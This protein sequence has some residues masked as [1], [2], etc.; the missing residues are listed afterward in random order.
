MTDTLKPSPWDRTALLA[1]IL[2]GAVAAIWTIVHAVLRII[3]IAPNRDVPVTASFADTA[4]TLPLGPDGAPVSVIAQQVVI[5]VSDMPAITLVSLILAE[6]VY[7]LTVVITIVCVCLVTRNL[8]AGRAFARSTVGLVGTATLTVAFGWVLTWLFTTM[9]A[10]G[11][12]SALS[13]R[14]IDNTSFSIDPVMLFAIAS[15]GALAFAF[16]AGGRLQRETE[17]LV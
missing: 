5:F 16:T 1:S 7:A 6:I 9:G 8:I 14:T 10:N 17:G 11:G 2:F 3:A 4:A 13:H 12:A 15:L